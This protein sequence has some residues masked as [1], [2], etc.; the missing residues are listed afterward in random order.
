MKKS[1]VMYEAALLLSTEAAYYTCNAVD[2][3]SSNHAYLIQRDIMQ[4]V[5][6]FAAS[7]NNGNTYIPN[8]F[9]SAMNDASMESGVDILV[10]RTMYALFMHEYYKSEGE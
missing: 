1:D 2:Q 6:A 4:D 9:Y 7:E 10:L 3:I 8:N 5:A